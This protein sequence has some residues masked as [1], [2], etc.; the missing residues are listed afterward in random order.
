MNKPGQYRRRGSN[1]RSNERGR[2]TR[3]ARV[4]RDLNRSC[5]RVRSIT[6]VLASRVVMRIPVRREFPC[7]FA[8]RLPI[9]TAGQ[10]E[11]TQVSLRKSHLPS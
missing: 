3:V 5:A 7:N 10:R 11:G 8:S 6:R 9:D 4:T 1:E 2:Q